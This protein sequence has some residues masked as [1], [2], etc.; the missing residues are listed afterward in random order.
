MKV[1]IV[2]EGPVG[3]LTVLLFIFFKK[4]H[5]IDDLEIFLYKSRRTFER[6]HV[7][8]VTKN[9]MKKIE[10]LISNCHNCLLQS[11]SEK[12]IEEIKISINC[13]ETI[14]YTKLDKKYIT[15]FDNVKFNEDQQ[16]ANHYD[17]IFLCD[18]YQSTNRKHF[19]YNDLN[20]APVKCVLYDK[21]ILVLY[22]NLRNADA[23]IDDNC[24]EAVSEK[25]MFT[26]EEVQKAG[27]D[28]DKLASLIMLVY[29]VNNRY[30]SL[31]KIEGINLTEKN[32]WST[33]FTNYANF[34][35][36]FTET[37]KYINA[38]D[39]GA[40]INVFKQFNV[41]ITD[42][43]RFFLTNKEELQKIYKLYDSFLQNELHKAN[44]SENSFMIHTVMPNFSSHGIILDD[45]TG[46][47]LFAKKN[48]T[49][50]AWLLGDSANGYPPGYS[51][52]A[53]L[54][55]AFFLI[56]NF[57]N[58][59]FR[60]PNIPEGEMQT[61]LNMFNCS[62][63]TNVFTE[64]YLSSEGICS[65]IGDLQFVDGYTNDKSEQNLRKKNISEVISIINSKSCEIGTTPNDKLLNLYNKYQLNQFF[66]NL[67]N[68]L[69]VLSTGGKKRHI[70]RKTYKKYGKKNN[71]S[72]KRKN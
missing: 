32:I 43:T 37:L 39:S 45:T 58:L 55:D 42:N 5:S 62:P 70:K 56:S 31:P 10:E 53:G 47:L 12:T 23:S 52:M 19:I 57:I 71:K 4:K 6:R 8:N 21:T 64:N 41:N 35:D 1:C 3:L 24:I 28:F 40:I 34:V 16:T 44:S 27:L 48:D 14:L 51:L 17:H 65:K 50:Y 15:I 18:G 7:I 63:E 11:L 38:V 61:Y 29:N 25:K 26:N 20:Y 59:N 30:N 13:L 67:K 66:Y 60:I 69:C 54:N 72:K 9:M 22:T 46:T 36:I 68:I 33:G 2:G 49:N